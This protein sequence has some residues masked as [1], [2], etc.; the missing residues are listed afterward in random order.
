MNERQ[1]SFEVKE[2][3]PV[4]FEIVSRREIRQLL[5]DRVGNLANVAATEEI[6]ALIF[7][8]KSARPISWLF[9]EIWRR[10]HVDQ[11]R[12]EIRFVNVGRSTETYLNR[13]EDSEL[14]SPGAIGEMRELFGG[15]FDGKKVVVVDEVVSSGKT[16]EVAAQLV[17]DSFPAACV[18]SVSIAS[19]EE[20]Q[21]FPWT[22]MPGA[23]DVLELSENVVSHSIMEHR[24]RGIYEDLMS[25]VDRSLSSERKME[26]ATDMWAQFVDIKKSLDSVFHEFALLAQNHLVPLLVADRVRFISEHI[27]NAFSGSATADSQKFLDQF[28]GMALL[29]QLMLD[30]NELYFSAQSGNQKHIFQKILYDASYAG[31]LVRSFFENI[32]G[33]GFSQIH[34]SIYLVQEAA[35]YVDSA[36]VVIL[37]DQL[38][39]EMKEIAAMPVSPERSSS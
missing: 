21:Y 13:T 25:R 6:D 33:S 38:R 10:E 39:A 37:A 2:A 28:V 18:S 16:L 23:T 12:P 30:L 36:R 8:D 11:K 31:S 24:V 3:K 27:D 15:Q 1:P 5:R 32:G 26:V 14:L 35:Q 20:V 19:A 22:M 34:P 9:R 7:L 17:R 29:D 4:E